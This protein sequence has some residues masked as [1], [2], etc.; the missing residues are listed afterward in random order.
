MSACTEGGA[1]DRHGIVPTASQTGASRP[2]SVTAEGGGTASP[3]LG[4]G[5]GFSREQLPALEE[6]AAFQ[7]PAAE[8]R[9]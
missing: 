5:I 1:C 9:S 7:A 8:V 6:L 4:G 3:T 2:G